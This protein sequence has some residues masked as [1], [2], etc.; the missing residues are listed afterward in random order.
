MS[1]ALLCMA[2]ILSLFYML[3]NELN[4]LTLLQ[5]SCFGQRLQPGG[6]CNPSWI[7][8]SPTEFFLVNWFMGLFSGSSNTM[9][10]VKIVYIYCVTSKL[11]VILFVHG[12][13][14]LC[15]TLTF[16]VLEWLTENNKNSALG[17][18][19]LSFCAA[20]RNQMPRAKMCQR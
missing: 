7:F 3:I 6:C 15:M 2:T 9:V 14:I 13:V 12:E 18:S 20:K 4:K 1:I 17:S 10:T 5:P 8:D 19:T 16:K 11:K